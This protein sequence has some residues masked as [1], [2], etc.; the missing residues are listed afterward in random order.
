MERR[1]V[2]C[3]T[4]SL[5]KNPRRDL[6]KRHQFLLDSLG[7]AFSRP[8][9]CNS[10]ALAV[11]VADH[12][13]RCRLKIGALASLVAVGSGGS[14]VRRNGRWRQRSLDADDAGTGSCVLILKSKCS[15]SV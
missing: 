9:H 7:G 10:S 8:T 1:L 14:S 5:Q 11:Q 12:F 13:N 15:R 2:T 3:A 6:V 4:V